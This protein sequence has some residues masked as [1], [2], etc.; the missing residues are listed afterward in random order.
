M[1]TKDAVEEE[2]KE[3]TKE[4]KE[5]LAKAFKIGCEESKD[6]KEGEEREYVHCE[7]G[8]K[9]VAKVVCQANIAK[10]KCVQSST[11]C[12]TVDVEK[13]V[14]CPSC[15]LPNPKARAT[16]EICHTRF[17]PK[18][19]KEVKIMDEMAKE[20]YGMNKKLKQAMT[21]GDAKTIAKV[22]SQIKV[23]VAKSGGVF[24]VAESGLATQAKS[25]ITPKPKKEKAPKVLRKCPCCGKD[26][27]GFFAMGHDGRVHGM[28]L[29]L[30]LGKVKESEVPKA[31]VAMYQVWKRDKSQSMKSVAEK[32]GK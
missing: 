22:K 25:T 7:D 9:R 12:M 30:S 2:V 29:K 11:G 10:G 18:P 5:A 6:G 4:Q 19:K 1:T 13:Q 15:G 26:V 16:C 21:A 24:K 27:G 17:K 32:M 31:V 20:L 8:Q 23:A 28:L 3:D 14:V